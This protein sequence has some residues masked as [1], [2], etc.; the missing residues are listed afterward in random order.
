M[1]VDHPYDC[2]DHLGN[3]RSDTI[4]PGVRIWEHS[5]KMGKQIRKLEMIAKMRNRPGKM[6]MRKK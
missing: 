1:T 6:K 5:A 2:P 4:K 3:V